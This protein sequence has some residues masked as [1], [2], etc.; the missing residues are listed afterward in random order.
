MTYEAY[1]RHRA[2]PANW[3]SFPGR[4]WRH[5]DLNICINSYNNIVDDHDHDDGAYNDDDHDDY[6]D[7]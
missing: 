6:D 7:I 1:H 4:Y 2:S 5:N 3:V